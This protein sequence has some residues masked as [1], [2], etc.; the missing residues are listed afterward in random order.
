[1]RK[2]TS[3]IALTVALGLLG[4]ACSGGSG[5]AASG[6]ASPTGEPATSPTLSPTATGGGGG[7]TIT[8]GGQRANDH[9]TK[10][11]SAQGQLEVQMN[12][13]YFDPTIVKGTPGEQVTIELKNESGVLHNFSIQGQSIDQDVSPGEHQTVTVTIPQSG[14]AVFFCKYHQSLGMVGALEPS[15]G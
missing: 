9:G 14:Q 12:D 4:A 11:V 6:T 7:G 3:L 13:F 5:T 1:M 10:D 8:I 15:S 2:R